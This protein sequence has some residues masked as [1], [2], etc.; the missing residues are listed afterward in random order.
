MRLENTAQL[1]PDLIFGAWRNSG[2]F[3]VESAAPQNLCKPKAEP[4]LLELC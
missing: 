1:Y 2:K 3:F 4:S